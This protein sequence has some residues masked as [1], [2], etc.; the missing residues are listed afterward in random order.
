MRYPSR[1][2]TRL[3]FHHGPKTV[4][5]SAPAHTHLIHH[6]HDMRIPPSFGDW[7]KAQRNKTTKSQQQLADDAGVSKRAIAFIE[8][9]KR[10]NITNRM[11]RLLAPEFGLTEKTFF[12]AI[13]EQWADYKL[14]EHDTVW[15]GDRDTMMAIVEGTGRAP[16]AAH[17]LICTIEGA[18]DISPEIAEEIRKVEAEQARKKAAN[19]AH[20]WNGPTVHLDRFQRSSDHTDQDVVLQLHLQEA[21][22]FHFLVTAARMYREFE[23]FGFKSGTRQK[24]VGDFVEWR[25]ETLP[26]VVSG[27]PLNLMVVTQDDMLVF[28]RRSGNVAV[29]ANVFAATIN[30]NLHPIEDRIEGTNRFDVERWIARALDQELGWIDSP[31]TGTAEAHLLALAIDIRCAIF[32]IL[33]YVRLPI[34]FDELRIMFARVARDRFE[35]G[36]G[37]K[38]S[39]LTGVPLATREVCHFIHANDL[40]NIV[41]ANAFYAMVHNN[42]SPVAIDDVF[43]ELQEAE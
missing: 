19:L 3:S 14:H 23:A 17:N 7:F 2:K 27:L 22:Y 32:G 37:N 8:S 42:L 24:L 10:Q 25:T 33:G 5:Q 4:H 30:E 18:I 36:K 29:A 43:R 1:P 11:I 26:G 40:Y 38:Q 16:I 31:E 21:Q 9:G 13:T 34:T 41:G 39:E 28:S 35:F 6:D 12:T 20:A 15:L